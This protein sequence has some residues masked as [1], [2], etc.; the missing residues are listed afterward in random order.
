MSTE[1]ESMDELK[2]RISEIKGAAEKGVNDPSSAAI[3]V[4]RALVLI[5]DA[6]EHF[7]Q[8][9]EDERS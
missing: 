1:K 6:V 3:H 5:A 8:E 9:A 4:C 2:K 7:I